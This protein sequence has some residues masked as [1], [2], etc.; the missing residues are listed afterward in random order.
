M[1][2]EVYDWDANTSHDLIGVFETTLRALADAP[3]GR[4][5]HEVRHN[6]SVFEFESA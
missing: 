6:V 5:E 3:G 2:F 4:S 1:Q